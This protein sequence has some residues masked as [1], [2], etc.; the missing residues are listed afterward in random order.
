M[1]R[2]TE[3]IRDVDRIFEQTFKRE[4]LIWGQ[5]KHVNV[6]TLLGVMTMDSFPCMVS[7]WMENGTMTAYLKVHEDVNVLQLV[8]NSG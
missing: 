7:E 8:C 4:L 2:P 5:A 3:R 1:L 6:L